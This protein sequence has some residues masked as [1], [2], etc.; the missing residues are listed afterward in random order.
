VLDVVDT[1]LIIGRGGNT[2]RSI[3]Q[4]T[5][6]RIKRLQ[7]PPGAREQTLVIWS[8]SRELPAPNRMG[9]NTAQEALIDCVKRVVFQ[10][11]APMGQPAHLRFL[12]GRSQE[13]GVV[14]K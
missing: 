5:G 3:E 2:V 6:G 13:A 14:E 7:E 11:N 1:A 10:E 12:I 8:N 9:R 4:A